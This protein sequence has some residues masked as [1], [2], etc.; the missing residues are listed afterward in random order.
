MQ[1][2]RLPVGVVKNQ[3]SPYTLCKELVPN[4]FS[5]LYMSMPST[6]KETGSLFL[7]VLSVTP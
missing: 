4:V 7:F 1:T 5:S 3:V 6:T 2:L